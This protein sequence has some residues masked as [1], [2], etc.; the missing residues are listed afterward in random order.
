MA[1]QNAKVTR[2]NIH[3]LSASQHQHNT[4]TQHTATLE[5]NM[6]EEISA[7]SQ[8]VIDDEKEHP[9]ASSPLHTAHAQ[10]PSP[11]Q[12][13][14]ETERQHSPSQGTKKAAQRNDLEDDARFV[15][16]ICLDPGSYYAAIH[17]TL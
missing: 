4:P 9:S 12:P 1:D 2:D 3:S 10:S 6:R 7:G 11:S 16:N 5:P 8:V 14:T 17:Y 15:C 13:Q